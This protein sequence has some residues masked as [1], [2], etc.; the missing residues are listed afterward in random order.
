[1]LQ[2]FV[3]SLLQF[4]LGALW[5]SPLLFGKTWM[6]IMGMN[7]M[8]KSEL[9]AMQKSMMPFY[10]L[11]FVLTVIYTFAI[12]MILAAL[13]QAGFQVS[14]FF[15]SGWIWLGIVVPVQ[16]GSVIWANTKRQFWLQQILIMT[17]YQLVGL[18]IATTVF[19]W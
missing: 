13:I 19:I 17:G 11:Q 18:A 7:H 9:Q 6:K 16:I 4:V 12:Y 10:L 1:M 2:L 15:V 5:Y 8:D 14:P 3:A